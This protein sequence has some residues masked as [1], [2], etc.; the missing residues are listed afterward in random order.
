MAANSAILIVCRFV[1][2][3]ISI[4]VMMFVS[5]MT[6]PAPKMGLPLICERSV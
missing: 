1:C 5:G 2:N 3:L 4:C 6:T